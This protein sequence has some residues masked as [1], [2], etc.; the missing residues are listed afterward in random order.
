FLWSGWAIV[1]KAGIAMII[2]LVMLGIYRTFRKDRS[3]EIHCNFRE[4][5]WFWIYIVLVTMVSYFSSFC[6]R[7]DLDL[8]WSSAII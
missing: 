5:I 7:G 1:S 3:E 8:Y 4:S 2:A 6:G